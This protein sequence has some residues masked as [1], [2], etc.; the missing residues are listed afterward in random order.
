M[1]NQ[2]AAE[3]VV[4]DPRD[5]CRADA[6][7]GKRRRDVHLGAPGGALERGG[8]LE[9]TG[10]CDQNGQPLAHRDRPDAVWRRA[11]HTNLLGAL[12]AIGYA[13]QNNLTQTLYAIYVAYY[14]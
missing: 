6:Q 1:A 14:A 2:V 5:P 9:R 13:V 3:A 7:L 8:V 10:S 11:D 12:A 4:A